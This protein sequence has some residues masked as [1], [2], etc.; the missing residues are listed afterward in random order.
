MGYSPWGHEKPNSPERLHTHTHMHA[1]ARTH[2]LSLEITPHAV[3]R[4]LFGLTF[5]SVVYSHENPVINLT[6]ALNVGKVR[7]SVVSSLTEVRVRGCVSGLRGLCPQEPGSVSKQGPCRGLGL[8]GLQTE[9][10]GPPE[11]AAAPSCP[12][13]ALR[14]RG[15]CGQLRPCRALERPVWPRDS[16]L[17][18]GG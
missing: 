6:A 12:G 2:E 13:G 5:T 4:T 7:R 18:G 15:C 9:A 11:G 8:S 1:H 16:A 14:G 3:Y 17:T 10:G